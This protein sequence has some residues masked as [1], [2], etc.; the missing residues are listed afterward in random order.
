MP[1]NLLLDA[2][3]GELAVRLGL[4]TVPEAGERWTG[5]TSTVIR[6][7]NDFTVK[8]AHDNDE[9]RDACAVHVRASV[10]AAGLGVMCPAILLTA[11]LRPLVLGPVVVSRFLDGAS[12]SPGDDDAG[13]WHEVGAQLAILHAADPD[14]VPGGLRRFVQT[15]ETDPAVMTR[16]LSDRGKITAEQSVPLLALVEALRP[17][18]LPDVTQVF[19]HGDIHAANVIARGGQLVGLVDFAGAGWLDSAW[20]FAAMPLGAVRS[21]VAGYRSMGGRHIGLIQRIAWCRL[22]LALE[23]ATRHSSPGIDLDQVISAANALR[24][25]G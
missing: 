18:V 17:D 22:Q 16:R 8:I 3:L 10:A 7:G 5:A 14:A 23:R 19:C 2:V 15:S 1:T 9:A 6:W 20:D 13:V 11:D 24:R 4:S 25:L 12:L 21:A